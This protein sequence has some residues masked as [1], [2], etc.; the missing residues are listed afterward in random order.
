M[1]YTVRMLF[2]NQGEP[3]PTEQ[4]DGTFAG[5][6]EAWDAGTARV[7]ELQLRSIET[8]FQ[9]FDE[10]GQIVEVTAGQIDS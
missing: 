8:A 10:A 7:P 9:V 3:P 2:L 6:R 1:A 5:L 4:L